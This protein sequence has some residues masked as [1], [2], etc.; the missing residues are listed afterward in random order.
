MLDPSTPE[1]QMYTTALVQVGDTYA[2]QLLIEYTNLKNAGMDEA[3]AVA[4]AQIR[5]NDFVDANIA[6]IAPGY[7][8]TLIQPLVAECYQE[9]FYDRKF[10]DQGMAAGTAATQ[11]QV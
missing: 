2:D 1:Y 8:A 5:A 3:S 11:S 9:Q 4:E 7:D 6:T 10:F